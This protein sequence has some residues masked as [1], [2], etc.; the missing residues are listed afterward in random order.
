ME[1]PAKDAGMAAGRGKRG[2]AGGGMSEGGVGRKEKM[3][4]G[5]VVEDGIDLY[6]RR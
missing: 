6:C 5:E 2:H 1:G 3:V 4:S